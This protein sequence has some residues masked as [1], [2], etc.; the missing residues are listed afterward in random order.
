MNY[1]CIIF[2]CDGVLVDSEAISARIF[3]QMISELGCNLDF[4]VVLE[5]ITGASMKDNLRFF[6]EQLGTNLP[7]HF[8][9]EFRKRS[10]AAYKFE[11]KPIPGVLDFIDKIN[12]PIGVASSGPVK[13]IRLNLATI[14]ILDKFKDNIFSCFDIGSWKPEPDIYL[15]AAR[16]MGFTPHECIVIED[17]EAGVKAAIA[18]RFRVYALANNM[19]KEKF[20]A[21]GANVVSSMPELSYLLG[22]TTS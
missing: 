22:F 20:K 9:Q 7:A 12:V 14:G 3:N 18:G 4:N 1:K 10:F 6:E 17:S 8:E 21:L 13:K 2:D 11:L 15:H 5:Q 16:Q 19:K